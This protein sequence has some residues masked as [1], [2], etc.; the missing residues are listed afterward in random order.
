MEKTDQERRLMSEWAVG[1]HVPETVMCEQR[2]RGGEGG[3]PKVSS[4][5][6]PCWARGGAGPRWRPA[7][8]QR[9][10]K[11]G[12]QGAEDR[13]Q[14]G[15]ADGVGLY[16]GIWGLDRVRDPGSRSASIHYAR[17]ISPHKFLP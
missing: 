16:R 13:W 6:V 17:E 9:V 11:A 5:E 3:S 14:E 15:E 4:E 12:S 10:S 8:L 2:H 7:H 1:I